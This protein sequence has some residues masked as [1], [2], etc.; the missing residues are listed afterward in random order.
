[1]QCA[2]SE[3]SSLIGVWKQFDDGMDLGAR[4]V[5]YLSAFLHGR[6]FRTMYFP[7]CTLTKHANACLMEVAV[8]VVMRHEKNIM[9][10]HRFNI[11][12]LKI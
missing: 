1:M 7:L 11:E 4:N 10:F 9:K 3:F 8:Q 5:I 6:N 2:L 12:I